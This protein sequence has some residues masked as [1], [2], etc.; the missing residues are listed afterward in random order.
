[1]SRTTTEQPSVASQ[2]RDWVDD[3]PPA[4]VLDARSAPGGP[5]NATRVALSHLANETFPPIVFVRRHI[6]WKHG[7]RSRIKAAEDALA[8]PNTFDMEQLLADVDQLK[9]ARHL[10]GPG[11]GYANWTAGWACGWTRHDAHNFD[12]AVVGR[13]PRTFASGIYFC[14]RK[15]EMRRSLTWDEVTL[16]EAVLGFIRSDGFDVLYRPGHDWM[17]DYDQSHDEDE[18]LWQWPDALAQFADQLVR[19]PERAANY[20]PARLIHS[21]RSEASAG[22]EFVQKMSDAADAIGQARGSAP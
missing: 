8:A 6:Y 15:N 7:C 12:I 16:T 10:A 17:C 1:M 11:G 19:H 4:T 5:S 18:C 9:V 2:V 13:P 14:S 21:A 22:K 3:A 20:S